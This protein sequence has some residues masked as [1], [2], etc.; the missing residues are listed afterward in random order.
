MHFNFYAVPLVLL[1]Q[2]W[3]RHDLGKKKEKYEL[4]ESF[5]TEPRAKALTE[6]FQDK[7]KAVD[8]SKPF[9]ASL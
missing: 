1:L 2:V 7:P 9:W 3:R 8:T 5:P 4:V 6:A